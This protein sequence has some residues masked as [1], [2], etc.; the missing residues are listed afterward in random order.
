MVREVCTSIGHRKNPM[1]KLRSLRKTV[2]FVSLLAGGWGWSGESAL[3]ANPDGDLRVE[4]ITAY[5]LIVDSNA[6]TPSSYAPESAYI[7][8]KFYNDGTNALTNV[9]AYIGNYDAGTPGTYPSRTQAPLVGPLPG[10][11]FA[12]EHEGGAMGATDATR[13]IGTIPPGESV[14]VYW[15]VDYPQLDENGNPVWGDSVKPDDDLWLE[16]DVWATAMDAGAYRQA[17]DTPGGFEDQKDRHGSEEQVHERRQSAPKHDVP[18]EDDHVEP[19]RRPQKRED[20][21]E[22]IHRRTGAL[23]CRRVE[24]KDQRR[25]EGQMHGPLDL[26]RK[27]AECGRIKLKQRK[28]D[29]DDFDDLFP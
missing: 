6:G 13:Y 25:R 15:L 17:D 12:L 14:A 27:D 21:V 1:S 26:G 16:Y 2:V 18:V 4:I 10:G 9:W 7:G 8:A 28:A 23:R 19:D 3:A 20:D 5:N 29:A 24:Q 11:A 22:R